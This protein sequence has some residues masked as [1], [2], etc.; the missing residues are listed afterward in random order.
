MPKMVIINADDLGISKGINRGIAE[1]H[2]KGILN[3]TSLMVNMP[4]TQGAIQF[5]NNYPNLRRGLHISLIGGK[6]LSKKEKIPHLV[7]KK[8]Y[9]VKRGTHLIWKLLHSKRGMLKDIETEIRA[10]IELMKDFGL[11]IHHLDS[12]DHVHIFPPIMNI[13][14]QLAKE[15]QI[16]WIRCPNQKF[17]YFPRNS[18]QCFKSYL[19]SF[20]S[21]CSKAKLLKN[22]I[23]ICD[24]F[25]GLVEIGNLN[26]A[27]MM[28]IMRS[29][30]DGMNE[31]VC[32]PGYV[33]NELLEIFPSAYNWENELK[34][35]KSPNV[36][37]LLHHNGI[38]LI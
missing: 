24:N 11:K 20:L 4:H 18:V 30:P 2:L 33:D 13:V 21:S 10:Q 19:I 27:A 8:G 1:A 31:I 38:E 29:I 35:L 34:A 32:H 28:A 26:E 3:S 12:H 15:Y 5:L 22:K 14:I 23:S 36:K 37:S 6:P 17:I 16:H 9:F 25:W 7:N